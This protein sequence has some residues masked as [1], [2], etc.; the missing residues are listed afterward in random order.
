MERHRPGAQLPYKVLAGVEPCPGGWLVVSGKLQGTNLFPQPPEIFKNFIEVLDY[1]PTYDVIALH[2][3]VGLPTSPDPGGR[4]CDREGRKMVGAARAAAVALAPTR[5]AVRARTFEE[6]WECNGGQLSA[7]LWASMPRIREVDEQ[8]QPYWQRTVYEVNPE[9][10]FLR[11][12]EESP[13]RFAK[14][15]IIGL[16]ERVQLLEENM[17]GAERIVHMKTPRG[18]RQRHVL[19]ALA[20]LWTA[21]RILSRSIVRIPDEPEWDDEGLRMEI[22]R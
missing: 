5:S 11:L 20:D 22:I 10:G 14:R 13:L 6:A 3:P 12:N 19:D 17:P 9:L 2:A 21:R 16:K 1:K 8:I 15:S 4:R 18:A 7:I